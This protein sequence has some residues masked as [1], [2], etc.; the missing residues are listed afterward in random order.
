M[1]FGRSA[2]GVHWTALPPARLVWPPGTVVS[3]G[4]FEI[5]G[6]APL[7]SNST[8]VRRWYASVCRAHQELPATIG[9][10]VGCFTFVGDAP[11]GPYTLARGNA[12]ILGYGQHG[13]DPEYAYYHRFF[14]AP[15][16][17]VLT[18]YQV[19]DS[20]HW[21]HDPGVRVYLSALKRLDVDPHDGTL[22]MVW[23]AAND[24]LKVPATR[25]Q[26]G[27]QRRRPVQEQL[28][29]A[30]SPLLP[31][32]LLELDSL[33]GSIVEGNVG[34]DGSGGL[35]FAYPGGA[36]RLRSPRR[37]AAGLRSPPPPRRRPL[38]RVTMNRCVHLS[39]LNHFRRTGS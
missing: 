4:C 31:V 34:W 38:A 35:C 21:K 17:V 6:V 8:S 39:L 22:R 19:Y 36:R 18:N 13:H 9:D 29:G 2:D 12:A 10:K 37:P 14:H 27:L 20:A 26:H 11:G 24:R 1:G 25:K 30:Q 23:W 32:L 16:G 33:H 7:R 28:D 15:G 5:G 3:P